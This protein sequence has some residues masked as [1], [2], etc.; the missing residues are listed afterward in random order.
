MLHQDT[1]RRTN[2]F[3]RLDNPVGLDFHDQLIEIG[4]LFY[5]STLNK[6]ADTANR[7]ERSIQNELTNALSGIRVARNE[8]RGV[9]RFE[10]FDPNT[11]VSGDDIGKVAGT[12]S[13]DIAYNQISA[14]VNYFLSGNVKLSVAYDHK[15]NETSASL[16]SANA[17]S[18]YSSDINNDLLSLQLQYKF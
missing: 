4:P 9:V 6:I 11:K 14:G 10:Q 2:R 13:T 3:L 7:A 1:R 8:E 5:A 16:K 12:S 15:M 18:D 17:R